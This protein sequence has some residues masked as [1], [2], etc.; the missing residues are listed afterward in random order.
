VR[1]VAEG[2]RLSRETV[3]YAVL[4][5]LAVGAVDEIHQHWIPG[6]SMAILDWMADILGGG[7]GAVFSLLLLRIF[8]SLI[9][10]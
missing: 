8:P 2:I 6:R 7:T 1:A 9:T 4:F 3:L 5:V 10:E